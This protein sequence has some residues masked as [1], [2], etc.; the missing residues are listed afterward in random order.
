MYT[1]YQM[2]ADL[3][4]LGNF[5]AV[6]ARTH[7]SVGEKHLHLDKEVLLDVS[8]LARVWRNLIIVCTRYFRGM[9]R[10]TVIC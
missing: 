6:W 4:M 3:S 2:C 5:A 1:S 8:G 9:R 7:L 10:C